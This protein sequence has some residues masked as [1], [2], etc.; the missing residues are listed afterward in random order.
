MKIEKGTRIL[1]N[2]KVL[3]LPRLNAFDFIKQM[4]V[5]NNGKDDKFTYE[6]LKDILYAATYKKR[7]AWPDKQLRKIFNLMDKHQRLIIIQTIKDMIDGLEDAYTD[8]K[9]N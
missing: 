5:V 7:Q 9:E 2:K 8:L 4:G 1:D 6:L 3:E